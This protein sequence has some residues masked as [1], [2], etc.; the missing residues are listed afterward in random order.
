MNAMVMYR[1]AGKKIE[2]NCQLAEL[3]AFESVRQGFV[4]QFSES[5]PEPFARPA[6]ALQ[7]SG[8][9]SDRSFTISVWKEKSGT[10]L[11]IPG[12]GQFMV[13]S[14]GGA[15][16]QLSNDP[17]FDS[18][19]LVQAILGPPLVLALAL[20]EVWCLHASAVRHEECAIAFLGE[21]GAGK[22]T[23]AGS[24]S[25]M[26][27]F[28]LLADDILPISWE[29]GELNGEL[30]ARPHF[31]QLKL[32]PDRQPALSQPELLPLR[33]L[34]LLSS[35]TETDNG[36]LIEPLSVQEATLAFVRHTVG[37]R[38][39]DRQ[40]LERHLDF[41]ARAALTVSIC[42]LVYPR[43]RQSLPEVRRAIWADLSACE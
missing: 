15:V 20:Q 31:P 42:R 24:I 41:C 8:M 37:A 35:T 6:K 7:S 21:S 5:Q 19:F 29:S 28:N 12:A 4:S 34:Y 18:T 3:Q 36:V 38:L 9:V 2:F 23:L 27:D 30:Q 1:L 10:I 33:R 43:R 11:D 32:P 25:E 39:F 26:K 14:A 13:A 22:S 17:P 40:L 16:Y